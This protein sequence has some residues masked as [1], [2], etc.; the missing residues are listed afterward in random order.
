MTEEV[1]Q[2]YSTLSYLDQ[3]TLETNF[4]TARLYSE[5]IDELKRQLPQASWPTSSM[6]PYMS[7]NGALFPTEGASKYF[8]SQ[9]LKGECIADVAHFVME[10]EMRIIQEYTK[11]SQALYNVQQM[12]GNMLG[13]M[14]PGMNIL[15]DGW[16]ANSIIAEAAN[17]TT[18]FSLGLG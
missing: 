15:L 16:T 14:I 5:I 11:G 17:I 3:V 4:V 13:R 10:A 18:I 12:V 7:I 9:L 8:Y 1:A 6:F 2:N